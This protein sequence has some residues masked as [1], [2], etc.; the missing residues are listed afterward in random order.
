MVH[1]HSYVKYWQTTRSRW[2]KAW[3]SPQRLC[4]IV[5]PQAQHMRA[6][7][8]PGSCG[9]SLGRQLESLNFHGNVWWISDPART[10]DVARHHHPAILLVILSILFHPSFCGVQASFIALQ[11]FPPARVSLCRISWQ[12]LHGIF[13]ALNT[14][15]WPCA[16]MLK[17]SKDSNITKMWQQEVCHDMSLSPIWSATMVV[18]YGITL[19][20]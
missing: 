12:K 6:F 15:M 20:T 14:T 17:I 13:L 1:F 5:Q 8:P 16:S 2:S 19:I 3:K 18:C 7:S 10:P 11:R 4:N 9:R